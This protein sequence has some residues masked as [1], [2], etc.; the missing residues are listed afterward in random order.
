MTTPQPRNPDYAA[1]VRDSF[2]RQAFMATIGA[3]LTDVAPGHVEMRLPYRPALGQQHGF[4][5]GG[6]IGTLADNA[7]GYAAFTLM[8]PEDS[9]LTV[10]YKMNI[11]SPGRGDAL[12]AVGTVLKPGRTLTVC[13]VK[14]YAETAGERKLCATAI[15]TLMTMKDM[16][17][18]KAE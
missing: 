18:D 9:I 11:V 8:S 4:F 3:E 5:H 6:V 13:E 2:G 1:R 10:E 17:D 12:V 14:V 16:S 15:C 7:G